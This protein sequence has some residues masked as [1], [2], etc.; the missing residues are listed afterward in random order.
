MDILE[1]KEK[2]TF[3]SS[4]WSW[5]VVV[6]CKNIFSIYLYYVSLDRI[7]SIV[8]NPM[9][10]YNILKLVLEHVILLYLSNNEIAII[11]NIK[12]EFLFSTSDATKYTIAKW[13]YL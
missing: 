8:N 5:V 13:K 9:L 7:I 11:N 3:L 4:L 12:I 2:D 1:E 10:H 6:L